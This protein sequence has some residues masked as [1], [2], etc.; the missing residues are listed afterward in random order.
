MP[1]FNRLIS[2]HADELLQAAV[3]Y[4]GDPATAADLVQDA[5]LKAFLRREEVAA[6]PDPRPWFKRLMRNQSIDGFR[7]H[8]RELTGLLDDL[9]SLEQVLPTAV[10]PWHVTEAESDPAVLV[11]RLDLVDH[12]V[13]GLAQLG[14]EQR[15][16][17]ILGD[18]E[19]HSMAELVVLLG[20]PAGTVKSRL[21]RAR[22]RLRA[23]LEEYRVVC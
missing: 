5:T 9:A 14:A 12:L 3:R 21:H 2:E 17:L 8:G 1:Q 7:K 6:M 20:V 4:A 13:A 10:S 16:V 11:E 15:D 18:I 22:A 19:G 23:V